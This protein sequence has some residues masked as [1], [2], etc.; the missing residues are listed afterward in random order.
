[1]DFNY[2]SSD[3]KIVQDFV[4]EI[5]NFFFFFSGTFPPVI[6]VTQDGRFLL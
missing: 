2:Q 5:M 6:V 1:M 4:K 3:F